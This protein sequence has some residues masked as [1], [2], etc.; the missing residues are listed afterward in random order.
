MSYMPDYVSMRGTFS[1]ANETMT[2][3]SGGA[4]FTGSWED[5]SPYSSVIAS[6]KSDVSGTLFIDA[7]MDGNSVD[8]TLTYYLTGNLSDIHRLTVTRRYYRIRYGNGDLDQS[9]FRVQFMMGHGAHL[10][11][12]LNANVQIDADA[13]VVRL[14]D[15][16][17]EMASGR[18]LGYR[19]LLKSGRNPD[20]D[21]ISTPE[22]VWETGGIYTGFPTGS[23]ETV[24][25]FS[26]NAG[27]TA[28]GTGARTVFV[29][30]LDANYNQI[31]ETVILS[32]TS[33]ALTTNAYKR[34]NN[35][36]V[37]SAGSNDFNLGTLTFR[38]SIT[39]ANV[40]LTITPGTNQ[41][42][43]AAFTVPSGMSA[44]VKNVSARI[45]GGTT[46]ALDGYFYV[47]AFGYPP[48]L[49]RPYSIDNNLDLDIAFYGGAILPEKTDVIPRITAC[50]G[51]NV[52]VVFAYDVVLVIE[53]K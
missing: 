43:C 11:T 6:L 45:R 18:F 51:L 4:S 20:I 31:N 30:G 5:V 46:A 53:K 48:R 34:I 42:A 16:E 14:T 9:V 22:D 29:E 7:S 26:S 50:T 41:S 19:V 13:V 8:N 49:R 33:N 27:D 35:A 10:S 3:L 32:G 40:F 12:P 23:A 44:Y 17:T 25:V 15:P 39:T 2:P 1:E 36:F 52:D 21:T 38:H 47:R 24:H 37:T 28:A